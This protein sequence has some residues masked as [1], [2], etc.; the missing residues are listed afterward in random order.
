MKKRKKQ[1]KMKNKNIKKNKKYL[2]TSST[3]FKIKYRSSEIIKQ[4]SV[5]LITRTLG[6]ISKYKKKI[7]YHLVIKSST[8][9]Y[10]TICV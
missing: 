2:L 7:I 4:S 1:E 5:S 9:N 3:F 8:R 6:T 10:S